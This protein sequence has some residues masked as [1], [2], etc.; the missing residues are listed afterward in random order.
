MI[1]ISLEEI[2]ELSENI[3]DTVREPLLTLDQDLR[4]VKASRSFYKFFKVTPNETIGTLIYNLGNKQWDIP[5][6]RE[7]LEKI[8]PNKTTFD[9]YEVE[10]NF[11]TIGKRFMLLNARQIK[12]AEGNEKIIL[13]AIEDITKRKEIE[14][15]LEKTRKELEVIKKTADEVS[16]FAENIIDT[17][18][19]PLLALDQ[20]LRVVKASRS[21]YE[22]FKVSSEETIGKLIYDLG[23]K[24]WD[25][26]KLRELLETILPKKSEFD[27]YEVEHNF[28]TIGKRVMVLNARQIERAEGNEKIILL[29]IV[30]I[31]VRKQMEEILT[32]S[33]ERYRRLFETADDGILLLDKNDGHITHANTSISKM[34]LYNKEECV[35]KKLKDIGF[36][37]ADTNIKDI[38]QELDKSGI[39]NYKDILAHPKA[40]QTFYTDIYMVDR[41]RLV[42]CNIRD[43]TERKQAEETIRKLN[44]DL[45]QRVIERTTEL[46]AA[47][48]ELESFSYSVSHDLKAP[49]RAITG[50]A[51][52][53]V[54]NYFEKIDDEGKRLINVIVDNTSKMGQLIEDL[55]SFSRLGRKDVVKCNVDMNKLFVE[56]WD[57]V[58]LS[59]SKMKI[60]FTISKLPSIHADHSLMQQVITNLLANA[61]KFTRFRD[62]AN[63]E[64]GSLKKNGQYVYYVK[65]NGVG[66]DMKYADKLYKVFQR[67]HNSREFEG[68]GVGLAIVN[69]IVQKH[70]GQVWAEAKTD[71]G[72]T[73]YFSLPGK[74]DIK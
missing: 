10:H 2:R 58:N 56:T 42:Q 60:N 73:F 7:L 50:F 22:S 47:N 29:A 61:V 36:S 55:L 41:A 54:E 43:I 20:D 45:E 44:E 9:N 34:L 52:A 18:R 57:E 19:E 16:Q 64:V 37:I 33:E 23:N 27:N 21:F 26:P 3:F 63:I 14:T 12:R 40:G 49:L 8:L 67:L 48:N 71:E 62:K 4:V 38:L 51:M 11:S 30:D 46:Q 70:G 39:I 13:L 68:S 31:T 65:D 74:G 35:G 17:V 5:K 25:I 69:K 66:F 32:E 28:S 59:S 15:G 72:A 6:L 1:K 24:Q 53:L